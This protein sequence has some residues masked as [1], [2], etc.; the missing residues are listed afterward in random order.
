MARTAG[1][2]TLLA[3]LAGVAA[4]T[5]T[6][7][8][9]SGVLG[10]AADVLDAFHPNVVDPAVDAALEAADQLDQALTDADDDASQ[11]AF[12]ALMAHWQQLEVMQAGALASSLAGGEDLRDEIYSWPTVNGCRVDQETVEGDWD[13]ATFFEDNL[14]NSYG[15]DA[16][17]H[18]LFAPLE[19]DCPSQVGIQGDW[20]ALGPDGVAQ[21]RAAYAH[22]LT[23]HV[24]DQLAS[25]DAT[26]ATLDDLFGVLFYVD[27]MTKDRKLAQPLGAVDCADA[28]CPDDVESL[29]SGLGA[30]NIENNLVGFRTVFT[31]GAAMG[32]DDLLV[33][34]GHGDLA[35][36]VLAETD[37][38]IA[39]AQAIEA[40]LDQAIRDDP[41]AVQE[42][43]DA[44]KDIT[45]L[46]KGDLA[47]VLALQIPSE[48]DG[49]ND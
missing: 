35:D 8:G 39:L 16:L 3:A 18:L 33:E 32:F 20:D 48:S 45:D 47:T 40:P 24:H 37:E 27:G 11:A 1:S 23:T 12:I 25:I 43:H 42:L 17:E 14:V 36:E 6:P 28:T 34:V 5:S 21:N 15:L 29:V 9:D 13:S 30:R 2:W 7:S 10:S 44:V 26:P 38:A 31:G 46:L 4:C 22:A 19:T 49:D 41:A